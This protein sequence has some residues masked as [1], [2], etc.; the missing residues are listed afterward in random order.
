MIDKAKG[1]R[2]QDEPGTLPPSGLMIDN[3]LEVTL[4]PSLV[5]V[6]VTIPFWPFTDKNLYDYIV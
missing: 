6:S 2:M 3:C 5:F 4:T 1:Q